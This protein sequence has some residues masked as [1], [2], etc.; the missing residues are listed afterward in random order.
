MNNETENEPQKIREK[1]EKY[2]KRAKKAALAL[3][4]E[5][6]HIFTHTEKIGSIFSILATAIRFQEY[7]FFS[8]FAS[9][10]Q[11]LKEEKP[12]LEIESNF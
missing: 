6:I 5:D 4:N 9:F 8:C 2:P 1:K 3:R 12:K 10:R 11:N 7:V